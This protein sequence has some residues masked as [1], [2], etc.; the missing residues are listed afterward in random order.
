M[1][2]CTDYDM[3]RIQYS[4]VNELHW[5]EY[6]RKLASA[7][8]TKKPT[9]KDMAI[10][11]LRPL[12]VLPATDYRRLCI[13]ALTPGGRGRQ[14]LFFAGYTKGRGKTKASLREHAPR[15]KE[16][17][18]V[19]NALRYLSV[20]TKARQYSWCE[21][22]QY[23]LS[24]TMANPAIVRFFARNWSMEFTKKWSEPIDKGLVAMKSYETLIPVVISKHYEVM[25]AYGLGF[26]GHTWRG[27]NQ[28]SWRWVHTV[29]RLGQWSLV[30]AGHD[31][32]F[33]G[34]HV[35]LQQN[36][37]WIFDCRQGGSANPRSAWSHADFAQTIGRM[38]L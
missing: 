36:A 37:L 20:K 32:I 5:R 30:V 4:S 2:V 33:K 24:E 14:Q 15:L 11:W 38:F 31:S 23:L 12:K 7:P 34:E 3:G 16:Q 28:Q 1:V 13:K 35:Q 29:A 22:L 9:R 10:S 21:F 27:Q 19:R 8:N 18:V 17:H 25:T 26:E 6:E